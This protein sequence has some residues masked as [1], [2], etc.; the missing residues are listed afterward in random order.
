MSESKPRSLN[1]I[2]RDIT[3]TWPNPYFGA[4]PYI[5]AMSWLGHISE[6]YGHDSARD[7]VLRFLSNASTWRGPDARRIKMELKALLNATARPQK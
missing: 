5:Q 1:K 7:V 3:K 4:V 6:S 2:A